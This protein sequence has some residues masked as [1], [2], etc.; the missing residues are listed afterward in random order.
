MERSCNLLLYETE[1]AFV[2]AREY[3]RLEQDF[4]IV[5]MVTSYMARQV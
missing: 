5:V 1:E 3:L 4:L 2:L